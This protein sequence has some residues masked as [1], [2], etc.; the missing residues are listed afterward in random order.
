M[1]SFRT[2]PRLVIAVLS[3]ALVLTGCGDDKTERSSGAPSPDSS[4]AAS[5]APA[6]ADPT[7][8]PTQEPTATVPA[9]TGPELRRNVDQPLL[10]AHAPQGWELGEN[11]VLG[12]TAS[13]PD[14]YDNIVLSEGVALTG[15]TDPGPIEEQGREELVL[16]QKRSGTWTLQ[17]PVIAGGEEMFHIH[18]EGS[19][20]TDYFGRYLSTSNGVSITFL[21]SDSD[22]A[23][24]QAVID[25][26]L[27]SV[28]WFAS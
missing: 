5:S 10:S 9:A 8:E 15:H 25:S 17:E 16:K 12:V 18:G 4:D 27:A 26:V 21:W 13:D 14:T 1:P 22:P 24:R 2:S 6:T 23:D 20:P 28:D 3:A 7:Q 11:G 19:T